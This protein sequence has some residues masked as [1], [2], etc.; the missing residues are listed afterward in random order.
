MS[1][2]A[3]G[4]EPGKG[5][6]VPEPPRASEK[7]LGSNP[8][9]VSLVWLNLP[10]NPTRQEIVDRARELGLISGSFSAADPDNF[11]HAGGVHYL[12]RGNSNQGTPN[13]NGHAH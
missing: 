9:L 7:L 11:W 1:E 5:F 13:G 3:P 12:I 2:I 8:V 4:H 10:R 6:R